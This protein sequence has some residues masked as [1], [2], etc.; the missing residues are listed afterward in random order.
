MLIVPLC[1]LLGCGSFPRIIVLTDPLTPEEHNDL[2]V[3]YERRGE[4]KLAEREYE[5]ALR[6][7]KDFFDAQYNLGN[8]YLGMK[9]YTKAEQAY[10]KALEI[11]PDQAEPCNNLANL[12]LDTGDLEEAKSMA[13]RAVRLAGG[14]KSL[15]LHTLGAVCLRQ[16]QTE[17]AIIHFQE[18]LESDPK[19]PDL[20][21][22]I[23]VD[24]SEAYRQ[25]GDEEKAKEY[26][27]RNL[28]PVK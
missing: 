21:K 4:C 22:C 8:L 5:E 16:G 17:E 26:R 25:I 24:L 27:A 7:R 10:R 1:F 13:E 20:L 2:G 3:S 6:L 19:D 11:G 23:W 28:A 14:H 15:C 12:Y 9:C 18:A